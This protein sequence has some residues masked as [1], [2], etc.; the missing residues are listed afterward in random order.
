M[1]KSYQK[2]IKAIKYMPKQKFTKIPIT[3]KTWQRGK[4]RNIYG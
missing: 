3:F 2:L 1:D 4:S